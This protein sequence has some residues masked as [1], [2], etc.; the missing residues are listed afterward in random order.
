[1]TLDSKKW[2]E[3]FR[4][5]VATKFLTSAGVHRTT[6]RGLF[7]VWCTEETK[8]IQNSF[9]GIRVTAPFSL[10][11]CFPLHWL[12]RRLS[13]PETFSPGRVL[14]RLSH[15]AFCYGTEQA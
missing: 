6:L 13:L 10:I 9:I 4:S 7:E 1:H 8:L 5:P 14:H 2:E 3:I 11:P 12:R 15:L